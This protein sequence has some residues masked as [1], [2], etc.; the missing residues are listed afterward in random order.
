MNM[1]MLESEAEE[2]AK[3]L[4]AL[5]MSPEVSSFHEEYWKSTRVKLVG[6]VLKEGKL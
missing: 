6:Q 2:Q 3:A 4:E 1:C 5:E